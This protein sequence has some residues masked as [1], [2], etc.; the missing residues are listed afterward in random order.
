VPKIVDLPFIRRTLSH[1]IKNIF[2]YFHRVDV[3]YGLVSRNRYCMVSKV[4]QQVHG[5]NNDE[6]FSP[7]TK[8]NSIRLV[9]VVAAARK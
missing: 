5:I 4:F 8:I 6:T 9:L 7:V 2:S 3:P 1:D